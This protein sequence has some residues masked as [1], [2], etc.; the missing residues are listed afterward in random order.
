MAFV[1]G[2]SK[3]YVEDMADG[4]LLFYQLKE[5]GRSAQTD[6]QKAEILELEPYGKC[7][8]LDDKMQSAAFD[9]KTYHESLVHPAMLAHPNPKKVFIAGGGEGATL[10]EVLRHKSVEEC[11]MCDID[12]KV[13]KWCEEM[14]PEWS[15]GAFKDKRATVV[16]EDAK[17]KLESYPEGYFDVIIFDLCDPLDGGPCYLL[18]AN[19]FYE[20]AK[21][22][23]AKN[24]VAVTQSAAGGLRFFDEVFTIIHSTLRSV[25]SKGVFPYTAEVPSFGSPW[26]YNLVLCDESEAGDVRAWEPEKVD[27]L[28]AE[29]IT[30]ELESYDGIAHRGLFH[31]HK[32]IRK[33]LEAEQRVVTVDNPVFMK[34]GL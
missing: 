17:A 21:S 33:G 9:E 1:G 7:L 3:Y 20:M 5:T 14:L 12:E 31:L 6:F 25:F 34:V 27:K 2:T 28:I 32:K 15:D 30:G 13:V 16:F 10:R 29:R 8:I 24:G 4:I 11:I 23:L 26:A 22:R 19:S 18:Y